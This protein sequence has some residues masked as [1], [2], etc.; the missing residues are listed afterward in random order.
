M[1]DSHSMLDRIISRM[2]YN[3]ERCD[4]SPKQNVSISIVYKIVEAL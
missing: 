3:I 4:D 2:N 1:I